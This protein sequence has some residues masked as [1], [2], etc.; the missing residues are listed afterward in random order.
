MSDKDDSDIEIT[1]EDRRYARQAMA[2]HPDLYKG[3]PQEKA[4]EYLAGLHGTWGH[5]KFLLRMGL[6]TPKDRVEGLSVE[7]FQG[8][9][10]EV[11]YRQMVEEHVNRPVDESMVGRF[12]GDLNEHL[13]RYGAFIHEVIGQSNTATKKPVNRRDEE[14]IQRL[15]DRLEIAPTMFKEEIE[16]VYEFLGESRIEKNLGTARVKGMSAPSASELVLLASDFA[17]KAWTSCRGVS[18][19]SKTQSEYLYSTE[20]A[21]LFVQVT[22]PKLPWPND[23]DA[24]LEQERS[25]A[26]VCLRERQEN[27]LTQATFQQAP[28][29]ETNETLLTVSRWSEL[30]IGIDETW[31]YWALTPAPEYGRHFAKSNAVELPLKGGQWK[32]LLTALA[33]AAGS[34]RIDRA[35]LFSRMGYQIPSIEELAFEKA[36]V[37]GL[38][39]S[40]GQVTSRLNQVLKDLRRKLRRF[41]DGPDVPNPIPFSLDA[42]SV[43]PE[44]RVAF[45]I[46]DAADKLV[47]GTTNRA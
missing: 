12:F 46:R 34:S 44:I 3:V 39:S 9:I 29:A 1:E 33:G 38:N 19:K 8:R 2:E 43:T 31:K 18:R 22:V 40:A 23:L 13:K 47:F 30:A 16:T 6:R 4:L 32:A 7:L 11:E 27:R 17:Q 15:A 42:D 26:R 35:D 36:Q 5:D 14:R 10:T 21:T 25:L 20:A 45:L 41:V 28:S 37:D 24:L